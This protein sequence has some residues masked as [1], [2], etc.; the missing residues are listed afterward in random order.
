MGLTFSGFKE[1]KLLKNFG[2]PLP[3][4]IVAQ[5]RP[6]G[7]DAPQ[8][9]L[10]DFTPFDVSVIRGDDIH[11]SF[12]TALFETNQINNASQ[13]CLINFDQLATIFG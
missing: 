12:P 2:A 10:W 9:L 11:V 5:L 13:P 1:K 3:F 6:D 7:T 8:P 4:Y